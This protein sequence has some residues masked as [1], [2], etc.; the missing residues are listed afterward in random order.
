MKKVLVGA[1]FGTLIALIFLPSLFRSKKLF[2]KSTLIGKVP[3]DFV[4]EDFSGNQKKISDIS[5]GN[6]VFINFFASW[7]KECS[8]EREKLIELKSKTKNIVIVGVAFND[9]KDKIDKY[10]QEINPYDYIA[11]DKGEIA[12][13]YGATGVPETYI[14][15]NGKIA[16]KIIGPIEFSEIAQIIENQKVNETPAER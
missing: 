12:L 16:R 5:N 7:C 1:I 4:S 11:Y 15:I 14:V 3:P 10:L 13:D 8:A 2:E 9:S 6:T